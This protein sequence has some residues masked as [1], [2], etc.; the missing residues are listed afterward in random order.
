MTQEEFERLL[1]RSEGET[2]DFK[3]DSY[4]LSTQEGRGEFTKDLL[5]MANTPRDGDAHIVLGVRWSAAD[6][7]EIIGLSSQRDDALYQDAISSNRVSPRP[8]F[9]YTPLNVGGHQVGVV[10]IPRQGDGPFTPT[11]DYPGLQ[12]G[13]V[14]VRRGSTKGRAVGMELS[15][16]CA[17]F[18]SGRGEFAGL[19]SPPAWR[20][21][22]QSIG[23]FDPMIRYLLVADCVSSDI[24]DTV[25]ALGLVPWR[26]VI[27]L[28]RGSE[29][30]GLLKRVAASVRSR[31]AVHRALAKDLRVQP[32][33]GIHW[34]FASGVEGDN[35]AAADHK[36]LCGRP[37][38]VNPH[39]A[40]C[41]LHD[42][43]GGRSCR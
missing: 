4:D 21:F 42:G 39:P 27:D 36:G 37:P 5:S 32:E 3:R 9:Y 16:I 17:W 8:K 38:R 11:G 30:G 29:A 1:A 26:A 34:Y 2:L 15:Q 18:E 12:A 14:Y 40:F 22:L 43:R 35:A 20:S 10:S 31:R 19:Q 33:P 24:A 7:S 23:A 28:D 13:A 25:E 6:G 41:G